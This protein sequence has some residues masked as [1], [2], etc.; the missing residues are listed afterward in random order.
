MSTA[1]VVNRNKV[2]LTLTVR[3]AERLER[4]IGFTQED[5]VLDNTYT[6]LADLREK[7]G[8]DFSDEGEWVAYLDGSIRWEENRR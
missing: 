1:K 4:L 2:V 7:E 6:D 3:Q 5:T 8:W